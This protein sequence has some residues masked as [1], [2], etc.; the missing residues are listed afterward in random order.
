MPCYGTN[1]RIAGCDGA[2][3][4]ECST[5][6]AQC[7]IDA[8][9]DGGCNIEG[10]G[11]G[12]NCKIDSCG[13]GCDLTCEGDRVTCRLGECA[14]GGCVVRDCGPKGTCDIGT[15]EGGCAIQRCGAGASTMKP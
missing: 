8:C 7:V 12:A 5:K 6:D 1:C 3:S 15:C 14:G 9:A 11:S 2:C 4:I 13:G 10:C